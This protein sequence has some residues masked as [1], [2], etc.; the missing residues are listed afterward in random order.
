MHESTYR[1]LAKMA[2]DYLEIPGKYYY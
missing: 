1:S 2:R